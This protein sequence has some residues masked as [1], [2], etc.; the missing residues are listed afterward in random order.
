MSAPS[1][2][3]FRQDLRLSD[4]PAL[5]A[6]AHEGTV[7][8]FYI[9]EDE[10]AGTEAMG[11]ASRVWLHHSLTAL[12]QALGN[13]LRVFVGKATDILPQLIAE[14]GATSLHWNRCYEPWRIS[15]DSQLKDTLQAQGLTVMS[16]KATLLWEPWE[17][18]K[19]DGTPYKVFT[20][21]YRRG[22]LQAPAPARPL[23]VP[24][25]LSLYQGDVGGTTLETLSLLPTTGWDTDLIA[26][27]QMGEAGAY[28]R[29]ETFLDEG[30]FVLSR[31][32]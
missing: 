9:L 14:T 26:G 2:C 31:G 17:P 27:W 4:N 24:S 23:P 28:Q 16:H 6:A 13:H 22:C 8:P 12:N 5:T 1:L 19:A 10:E 25:D 7:L 18:L 20:P 3:W 30:I 29:L 32:A 21:F 15:R 11:A